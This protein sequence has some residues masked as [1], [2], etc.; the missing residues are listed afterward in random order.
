MIP[1]KNFITDFKFKKLV[2]YPKICV[3]FLFFKVGKDSNVTISK[4]V[5]KKSLQRVNRAL[6]SRLN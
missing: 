5:K 2:F 6:L 4:L 1:L 3:L